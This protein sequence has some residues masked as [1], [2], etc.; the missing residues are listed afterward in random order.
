[1]DI[2]VNTLKDFLLKSIFNYGFSF[3]LNKIKQPVEFLLSMPIILFI[4]VIIAPL[5]MFDIVR[6]IERNY[7][8]MFAA[9]MTEIEKQLLIYYNK[10]HR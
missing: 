3:T 10:K 6:G 4:Y 7:E 8:Y 1:M 5:I 9:N 2:F